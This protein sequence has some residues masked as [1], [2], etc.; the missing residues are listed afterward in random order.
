[1]KILVSDGIDFKFFCKNPI[2]ILKKSEN[3]AVAVFENNSPIFYAVSSDFLEKLFNQEHYI[4]DQKIEKKNNKIKKFAMHKK[5]IPDSD[6]IQ[7]SALWGIILK[8]EVQSYELAS[9]I[10]YWQAEGC[11][12]YHIQWQQ[13]LARS[14]QNSRSLN[15]KLKKQRDITHI[16][17]PDKTIPDGFRGK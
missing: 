12:F 17:V 10:A 2:N 3:G 11:F 7:Q 5:W 4:K 13:K 14:L 6:F 8:E 1:M 9:F 16:P 15:Y